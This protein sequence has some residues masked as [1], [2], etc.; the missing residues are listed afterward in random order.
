MPPKDTVIQQTLRRPQNRLGVRATHVAVGKTLFGLL[1]QVLEADRILL[2]LAARPMGREINR[3]AL[4]G[5]LVDER[6]NLSS[7]QEIH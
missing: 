5:T 1:Q 2:Y 6:P 7:I 4:L 3:Y